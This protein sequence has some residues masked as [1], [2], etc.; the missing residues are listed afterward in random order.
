MVQCT[1]YLHR[2]QLHDRVVIAV[3]FHHTLCELHH[4]HRSCPMRVYR[5]KRPQGKGLQYSMFHN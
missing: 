2:I 1:V 5:T 3:R 4:L